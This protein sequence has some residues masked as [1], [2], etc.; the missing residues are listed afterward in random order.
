M[1]RNVSLRGRRVVTGTYTLAEL[2]DGGTEV[3]FESAWEK[4]PWSERLA[5]LVVRL[6]ARRLTERAMR[7][8]ADELE[9]RAQTG[10]G[11]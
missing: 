2:P 10:Y 7:R 5:S 11:A 3:S 8:L 4:A 1:E 9:R 6:L